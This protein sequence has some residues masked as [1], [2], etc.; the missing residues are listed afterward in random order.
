M[1][2]TGFP[3]VATINSLNGHESTTFVSSDR[4]TFII[5]LALELAKPWCNHNPRVGL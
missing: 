3:Y 1:L 2:E 4:C 5:L